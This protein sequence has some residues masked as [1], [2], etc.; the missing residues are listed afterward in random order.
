MVTN[1]YARAISPLACEKIRCAGGVVEK[2][3]H[4]L[5]PFHIV[6]PDGTAKGYYQGLTTWYLPDGTEV[7]NCDTTGYFTTIRAVGE[8][9]NNGLDPEFIRSAAD[10]PA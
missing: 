2:G 10:L 5:K 6:L 1:M 8:K 3:P 7:Q 4:G 9:I